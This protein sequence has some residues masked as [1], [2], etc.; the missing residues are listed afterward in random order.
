MRF[1]IIFIATV[2][3]SCVSTRD[4]RPL[5][6]NIGV[7]EAKDMLDGRWPRRF[8]LIDGR[9]Q[10][11]FDSGHISGATLIDSRQEDAIQ[12]LSSVLRFRTI[13]VYCSTNNRTDEIV[14]M[15]NELGYRGR[16]YAINGGITAWREAGFET[17]YN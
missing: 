14:S 4:S 8:L 10:Q 5:I 15:L 17:I 6:Q 11:M 12:K 16:I 3:I 2:L 1:S 9:S 7:E 13:M